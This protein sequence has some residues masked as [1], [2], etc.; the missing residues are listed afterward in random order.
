[1]SASTTIRTSSVTPRIFPI[2]SGSHCAKS[3]FATGTGAVTLRGVGTGDGACTGVGLGFG[4]GGADGVAAGAGVA[5][6]LGR[7]VEVADEP[8][9]ARRFN[10][11][12]AI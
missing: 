10:L 12:C 7:G 3:S 8:N 1:M 2:A 6:A 4:F 11:I 5:G 9:L